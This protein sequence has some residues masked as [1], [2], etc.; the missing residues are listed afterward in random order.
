MPEHQ[1]QPAQTLDLFSSEFKVNPFPTYAQMR[2]ESPIY[3][4]R[5][6]D[7]SII[8]YLTKYEDVLAVLRDNEHFCKDPRNTGMNEVAGNASRKTAMHRLIN[9]NM[10]FSDPPDHTRLRSLVSQ[11]F[12]PQRIARQ[13]E[14][15]HKTAELLIQHFQDAGEVDLIAAYAFP[16]PVFVI[17]K[18]LG[19]PDQ[20]REKVALWS[21]S[22]ISPGSRNLNFSNRKQ[23]VQA[24]VRYLNHLFSLRLS[25]PQ[26]DLISALV[27]A[28][29]AG[30]KLSDVELSS[31]VIL[32]IVTGHETTVNLIGNGTLALLENPEQLD[33]LSAEPALW[34]NAV[35][36]LLRFDG[37]VETSTS[38]WA[39]KDILL[40]GH[41]IRRGDQVRVVLASA[42]R[43][44]AEFEFADELRI[45]RTPNN[46][47]AFGY[48][49]HYC[50]G[51]PLAR[52]EA[53]IALQTLF[54][55]LAGLRLKSDVDQLKW[56]KGVL[57]RGLQRLDLQWDQ[58]N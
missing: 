19:I 14:F 15:I 40:G 55:Q 4:H 29:E 13:Q 58:K 41:Q 33:L 16:L 9:E 5:A 51:A 36:E 38:R 42:N 46:H 3:G 30:D 17:C 7:G 6:P 48:G 18:L 28:E 53:K 1:K 52:L 26:D 22:I 35:E 47:L 37:P 45:T 10:L 12:T 31:M 57:F 49:I 21:Q 27:H 50:L 23:R 25:A 20:D 8:W 39:C 56:R 44:R 43:D 2:R 32:L 34:E 24:L 11:A 54:E